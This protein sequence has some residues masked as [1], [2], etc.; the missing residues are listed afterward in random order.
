MKQINLN[1]VI[2]YK[3]SFNND[4]IKNTVIA[5][6]N[7]NYNSTFEHPV[8]TMPAEDFLNLYN[9]IL[10]DFQIEREATHFKVKKLQGWIYKYETG[11]GFDNHTKTPAANGHN[12]TLI[13]F[14]NLN[15]EHSKPHFVIDNEKIY[16]SNLIENDVIIF[17][18]KVSHG[19]D[20]NVSNNPLI[21]FNLNISLVE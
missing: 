3:I 20:A 16:F 12:F 9:E 1:G 21:T 18:S 4:T 7:N 11:I 14:L 13:H 8:S 6:V 5:D 10:K 17:P 15:T 2:F 19:F